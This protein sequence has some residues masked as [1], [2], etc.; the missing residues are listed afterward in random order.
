MVKNNNTVTIE[1]FGK[2]H[3]CVYEIEGT[4]K[5]YTV[6][7]EHE[8]KLYEG[9]IDENGNI[10]IT[11]YTIPFTEI[12]SNNYC[13][14]K[15]DEDSKKYHSYHFQLHKDKFLLAADIE[16]NDY[17]NCRLIPSE[18]D[19]FWFIEA[20]TNG[21]REIS[22]YD[23][24]NHKILTPSFTEISF[25]QEESRVLAYIEKVLYGD[26][27]GETVYLGSVMSYIDYNGNFLTPLYIPEIDK[28]FETLS[29]N[30][31]STFKSFNTLTRRIAEGL[32]IEY[33]KKA[34][35]V[36]ER[37]EAMYNNLYTEEEL[38]GA[39]TNAKILDYNTRRKK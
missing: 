28:V 30:N 17:T 6:T 8:D 7:F 37:L 26:V 35:L 25:E 2:K 23:V 31:D 14:T 21:I 18:K 4:N 33:K 36:N 13:F 29:Y 24:C 15:Y 16:G 11:F 22:L 38:D 34:D 1:G 32:M 12:F 19:N 3:V 10:V 20:T 5:L 27:D 39:K 9:T